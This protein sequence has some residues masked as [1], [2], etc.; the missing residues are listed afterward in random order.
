MADAKVY[1]KSKFIYYEACVLFA[2]NQFKP[3]LQLLSK[4]LKIE[5]D[6]AGWNIGI[7]VLMAMVFIELNKIGEASTCIATLRKH[8]ERIS[9]R[10]EIKERDL[11]ILKLLRELEKD[12]FKRNE[13]N[14]T[15]AKLFAELSDKNKPTAWNYYT[16]ELIPFHEWAKTLPEKV[17]M[18]T[19]KA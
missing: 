2:T 6:K 18:R 12:G 13:K 7:R 19:I 4:S 9:K 5:K 11:L 8:I 17:N 3:A 15:A 14:K 10:K 16:P 1:H